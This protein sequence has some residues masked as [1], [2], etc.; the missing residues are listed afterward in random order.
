[1]TL[2]ARAV[3]VGGRST[4]ACDFLEVQSLDKGEELVFSILNGVIDKAV[5]EQNRV[6]SHLDLSNGLTNAYFEF[7]FCLNSV[8][9]ATS[10]FFEARWV[11]KEEIALESLL[12]DLNGSLNVDL[13][14]GDF[15][16]R[17]NALELGKCGAIEAARRLFSALNELFAGYHSLEFDLICETEVFRSLLVVLS[18]RSGGN[19]DL[20]IKDV[21]IFLKNKVNESALANTRWTHQNQRFHLQRSW[22]ERMEVLLGIDKNVIL[23]NHSV[24]LQIER[25][26]TYWFGE[27]D[28]RQ[29]VVENFTNFWVSSDVLVMLLHKFIFTSGQICQYLVVKVHVSL[30]FDIAS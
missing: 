29:E 4:H 18:D 3:D 17:L 30:H 21:S 23:Q 22:V 2:L 12:V 16:T 24:V 8:S 20:S 5:S 15:V 19:R 6:V 25:S 11:D 10:E 9:N 14:D 26:F 28:C 13:D 1:M 27:K 7:L